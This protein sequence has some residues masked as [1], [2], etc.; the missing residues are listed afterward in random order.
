MKL[1]EIAGRLADAVRF[2][3]QMSA[4]HRDTVAVLRTGAGR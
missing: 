1:R 2:A 3:R 4:C